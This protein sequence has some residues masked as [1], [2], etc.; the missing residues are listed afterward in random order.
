MITSGV[1][2]A[3]ETNESEPEVYDFF[4]QLSASSD[5]VVPLVGSWAFLG[6][7]K[8]FC[9][10]DKASRSAGDWTSSNRLC[11]LRV[12]SKKLLPQQGHVTDG[13]QGIRSHVIV[14]WINHA[15][16]LRKY[17]MELGLAQRGSEDGILDPTSV[18]AEISGHSSQSLGIGNIVR[19]KIEALTHIRSTRKP[20]RRLV[21]VRAIRANR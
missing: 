13:G 7:G 16:K 5:N 14:F 18:L 9:C 11:P 12:G 17:V 10:S 15:L 20:C 4:R 2:Y 1:I 19:N 21:S 8:R 6:A 3:N